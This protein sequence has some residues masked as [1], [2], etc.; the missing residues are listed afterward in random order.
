MPSSEASPSMSIRPRLR[1]NTVTSINGPL[2]ILDKV[3]MPLYLLQDELTD[4][5]CFSRLNCPDTTTLST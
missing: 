4:Q 3:R 5:P 2:V 1:Y